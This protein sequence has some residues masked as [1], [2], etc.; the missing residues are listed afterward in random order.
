MYHFNAEQILQVDINTAWDFFSSPNN[1]AKITPP[2]LSFNILTPFNDQ[3]ELFEGMQIDYTIKPLFGIKMHWESE[4]LGVEKLKSFTD[5]QTVGPYKYW[6][7]KHTFTE[8]NGV[9]LMQDRVKYEL[10]F[11][12]IGEI[13][14]SLLV[15]KKLEHIFAYR[16][17]IL[18]NIF[19]KNG[20][21]AA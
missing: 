21:V 9:V 15:R 18:E 4:I 7:H 1:L 5:K 3:E 13:A 19:N 2:E 11:G 12:F 10:P 8:I 20:K 6:E 14:H 16:K 17:Q